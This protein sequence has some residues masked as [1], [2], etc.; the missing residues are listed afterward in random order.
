[1]VNQP[2]IATGVFDRQALQGQVAVV[3]G[4]GQGIGFE[5]AR[6]LAWLGADVVIAEISPE[7]KTAAQQINQEM[8]RACAFYIRTDVSK[9]GSVKR[10]ARKVL[11]TYGK[12]DIVLNNA[13]VAPIG[14]VKDN[15]IENWDYSYG[16]NLRGPVLLVQHFLPGMLERDYG[17][18]VC[19]TSEGLAHMGAYETMKA[20]QAHLA[21]TL[22]AELEGTGVIAFSI[23]PGLVRT[24]TAVESIERLAPLYGKSVEE[25][26]AM[27]EE[28]IISVE[29]AGAAFAAAIVL[30]ARFRGQEM[31]S[32]QALMAAGIEHTVTAN[33]SVNLSEEGRLRALALCREITQTLR[34]QS[35]GWLERSLFERQWLLRDF[36]KAAGMPVEQWLEALEKLIHLLDMGDFSA[37]GQMYAPLAQLAYFYVHLQE[38]ARGYT[39]DPKELEK[40]LAI[41]QH[42]QLTVEQLEAILKKEQ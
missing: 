18:L 11:H 25:F 41:V 19:V 5:A 39:Q 1:M 26:Y 17:V 27:N 13:T 32:R 38:L 23:G 30:A 28:H 2:L 37:L 42:W 15:P 10:F 33:G 12:V 22:D 24:R 16:V 4:A 3:T 29:E 6:S 21:R 7:G 31:G 34:E 35:D 36:K 14:A 40:H 9:P 20:A 8:G